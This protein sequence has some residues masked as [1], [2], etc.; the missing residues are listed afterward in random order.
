M[1]IMALQ[2]VCRAEGLVL[3]SFLQA[4][5][6]GIVA[7]HAERRSRLGEMEPIFRRR[8]RAGLVGNVASVA[9]HVE[10][11]MTA[12]LFGH[13]QSRLVA[14]AAEI[15]FFPARCRL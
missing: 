5:I 1:G 15:L 8:F 3:M 9:A 4:S 10:R 6:V 7:L 13:I 11:G 2:T 12:A 14:V